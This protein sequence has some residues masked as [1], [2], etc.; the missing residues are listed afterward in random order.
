MIPYFS[1]DSSQ[2]PAEFVGWLLTDWWQVH[3]Q[4]NVVTARMAELY[5]TS[6]S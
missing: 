3:G 2:S 1:P 5:E 6:H 4:L